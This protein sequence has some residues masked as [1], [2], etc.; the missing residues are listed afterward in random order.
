MLY[1][2]TPSLAVT[3]DSLDPIEDV[4]TAYADIM[5]GKDAIVATVEEAYEVLAILGLSDDEIANKVDFAFG[6]GS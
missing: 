6:M 3:D 4:E 1:W 2:I 5:A